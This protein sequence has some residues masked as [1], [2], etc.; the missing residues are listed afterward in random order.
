MLALSVGSPPVA[1]GP[2]WLAVPAV[3][4]PTT[5]IAIRKPTQLPDRLEQS[6]DYLPG[7]AAAPMPEV[8]P[9]G[10]LVASNRKRAALAR[11]S[12]ACEV[13]Q[14]DLCYRRPINDGDVE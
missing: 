4:A 8:T 14:L 5:A 9:R 10:L 7:F 2:G 13:V 6:A 3:S 12:P 11:L 1:V